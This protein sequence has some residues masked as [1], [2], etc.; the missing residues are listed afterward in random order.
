MS[1]YKTWLGEGADIPV[2]LLNRYEA[3]L[4][5]REAVMSYEQALVCLSTISGNFKNRFSSID[6]TKFCDNFS[7]Q[8]VVRRSSLF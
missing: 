1:E 7:N 3:A 4:K 6:S 5:K 2:A 8:T